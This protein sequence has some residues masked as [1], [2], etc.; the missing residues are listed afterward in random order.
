MTAS[1][2]FDL[3]LR[4]IYRYVLQVAC[5]LIIG[6]LVKTLAPYVAGPELRMVRFGFTFAVLREVSGAKRRTGVL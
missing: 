2:E 1:V 4:G 5:F 3:P 6:M